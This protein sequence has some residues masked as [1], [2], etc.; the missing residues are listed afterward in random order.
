MEKF[1]EYLS[2]VMI[3]LFKAFLVLFVT[4]A[5]IYFSLAAYVDHRLKKTAEQGERIGTIETE[6][7]EEEARDSVN[8]KEEEYIKCLKKAYEE[9]RAKYDE[10]CS[11]KII[12]GQCQVPKEK[13]YEIQGIYMHDKENCEQLKP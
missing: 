5:I 12:D 10:E 1:F 2:K 8:S 7:T 6:K 13:L 3:F 4:G 11:K 9:Y